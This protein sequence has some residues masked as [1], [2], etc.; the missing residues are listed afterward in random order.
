[1]EPYPGTHRAFCVLAYYRNGCLIV[2]AQRMYRAEYSTR[3]APSDDSIR[4]WIRMFE[5]TGATVKIQNSGH[6]RYVR[7]QE[8]IEEVRALIRQNPSLSI[9]K[10]SQRLNIKNR[11]YIRF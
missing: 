6:P 1:M 11:L 10:R 2:T 4:K 9:R 3:N 8:I 5:N 7:D